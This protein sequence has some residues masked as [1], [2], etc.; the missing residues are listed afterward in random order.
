MEIV[1]NVCQENPPFNS[2]SNYSISFRLSN[3]LIDLSSSYVNIPVQIDETYSAGFSGSSVPIG[4]VNIGNNTFNTSSS[5]VP[6]YFIRNVNLTADGQNLIYTNF[7]NTLSANLSV[8]L[9]NNAEAR[10][11]EYMASEEPTINE[12]L[13]QQNTKNHLYSSLFRE[14]FNL[15]TTNSLANDAYIRVPLKQILGQYA[16]EIRDLSKYQEVVMTLQLDTV[17]LASHANSDSFYPDNSTAGKGNTRTTFI[18]NAHTLTDFGFNA[19]LAGQVSGT[20]LFTFTRTDLTL[21]NCPIRVNDVINFGISGNGKVVTAVTVNAGVIVSISANALTDGGDTIPQGTVC[22][23]G[24][25]T[26]QNGVKATLDA[27]WLNQNISCIKTADGLLMVFPN[28]SATVVSTVQMGTDTV[29]VLSDGA[30]ATIPAGN[31]AFNGLSLDYTGN[32]TV[33]ANTDIATVGNFTQKT[34]SFWVGQ[35]VR[36]TGSANVTPMYCKISGI[37]YSGGK[38]QIKLS[39]DLVVAGGNAATVNLF[40]IH[41]N[42]M[43]ITLTKK[44]EIVQLKLNN[45]FAKQLNLSN[46]YE[47]WVYDGDVILPLAA[48]SSYEKTFMLDPLTKMVV[49]CITKDGNLNST[50]DTLSKYRILIDGLDTTNRDIDLDDSSM[51]QERLI[52]GFNSFYEDLHTVQVKSSNNPFSVDEN[53]Y[54]I[55]QEIPVDGREHKL[56]LLLKNGGSLSTSSNLR[57]YKLVLTQV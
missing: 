54:T 18:Q 43:D 25:F 19:D 50:K 6:S 12:Q 3:S 30:S 55:L 56:T 7:I 8:Y 41:P 13:I 35:A 26:V 16:T 11:I 57:V 9:Y 51:K 23:H 44:W 45:A 32:A 20:N 42:D 27:K 47:R 40:S 24:V 22:T 48:Y 15:G 29:F 53:S 21:E 52:A 28:D 4:N 34:L 2:D 39:K 38:A 49:I 10:L 1:K 33:N 17:G 36:I 46:R 14:L 31:L 37:T 5:H